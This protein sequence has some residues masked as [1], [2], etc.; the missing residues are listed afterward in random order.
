[1]VLRCGVAE[2]PNTPSHLSEDWLRSL[3]NDKVSMIRLYVA[4]FARFL[5]KPV[6]VLVKLAQDEHS[7]VRHAA[8][9]NPNITP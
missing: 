6:D 5:E 8:A 3:A 9:K 4:R 1:M 7:E 2:N